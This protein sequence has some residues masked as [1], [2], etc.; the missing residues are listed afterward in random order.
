M[1]DT[2]ERKL[3]ALACDKNR[4]LSNNSGCRAGGRPLVER[5]AT[6]GRVDSGTAPRSGQPIGFSRESFKVDFG[7]RIFKA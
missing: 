4:R 3:T 6:R 5:L 1:T 2:I 7:A